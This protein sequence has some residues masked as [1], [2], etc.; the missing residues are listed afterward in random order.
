MISFRMTVMTG[1]SAIVLASGLVL[2]TGVA[3]ATTSAMS[4]ATRTHKRSVALSYA[5]KQR[6]C[7]YRYGGAGPCSH[8]YDCSGLV[9]RAY[10]KAG[11]KL[12]HYVPSIKYSSHFKHISKKSAHDGDLVFWG[13]YHVEFYYHGGRF[14]AHHTGTRISHESLYGSPTFYTLR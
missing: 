2:D 11:V 1:V 9:M 4:P 14:G 12:S 3:H 5:L 8:G 7:W 10:G 13:S 6:G